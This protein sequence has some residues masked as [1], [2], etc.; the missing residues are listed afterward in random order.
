MSGLGGFVRVIF[1][2]AWVIACVTGFAWL[3]GE[4]WAPIVF[5]WNAVIGMLA[6]IG[7]LLDWHLSG[8][9]RAERRA[10]DASQR[11][12]RRFLPPR[13]DWTYPNELPS[14]VESRPSRP[15]GGDTLDFLR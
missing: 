10:R 15:N 14:G 6:A 1:V 12:Q 13:A 8:D 7:V 11:E 3:A 9:S 4:P 2:L 5:C